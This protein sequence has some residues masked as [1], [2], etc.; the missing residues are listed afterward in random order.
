MTCCN[1]PAAE[2]GRFFSWFARS[3]RRCYQRKGLGRAQQHLLEGINAQH[4]VGASI[5]DIGCGVGYLH[6]ALLNDGAASATGVDL[7]GRMLEEARA[8][9]RDR[10]LDTRTDYRLGDFVELAGEL[11]DADVTVLDKVVCC[12]PDAEGLV[13]RSVEKTRRV[14]ALSYPRAHPVNRILTAVE[15]AALR[16]I[17]CHFRPYVHDP[18][19][20]ERWILGRGFRKQVQR[21]TWIWLT[22]V[23]VR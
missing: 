16:L 4:I 15:G 12:Y 19:D 10:R 17:R 5:L 20:I 6:Q 21:T 3:S 13:Q 22:Q 11:P 1:P 18:A 23:Y 14:Y 7:S 9:A 8:L 2:A